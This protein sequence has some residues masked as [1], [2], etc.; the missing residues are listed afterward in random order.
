MGQAHASTTMAR[1]DS[2]VIR[3]SVE[4]MD[5]FPAAAMEGF[6]AVRNVTREPVQIHGIDAVLRTAMNSQRP[7]K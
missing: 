6:S 5:V 7:G 4:N 3:R 1:T 2:L